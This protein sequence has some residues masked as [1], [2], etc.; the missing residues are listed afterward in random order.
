MSDNSSDS[1][2]KTA[3]LESLRAAHKAPG[4][5]FRVTWHISGDLRF[6]WRDIPILGDFRYA[7]ENHFPP[8]FRF[9]T[10]GVPAFL[11][12]G[13]KKR[14]LGLGIGRRAKGAPLWRQ[15]GGQRG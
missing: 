4:R 14:A 9:I 6:I 15:S 8:L 10:A 5:V 7:V 2:H 1:R 12:A 11:V 13:K 3:L